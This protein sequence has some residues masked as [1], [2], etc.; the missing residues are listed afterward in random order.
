VIRVYADARPV[1]WA[2]TEFYLLFTALV[3]MRTVTI[4]RR[5]FMRVEIAVFGF[6]TTLLFGSLAY[7]QVTIDVSKVTCDQFANGKVG[8]PRTTAI[9]L[10]GYYHGE[11]NST[12]IDAQQ[13][14][15]I[16]GQLMSFCRTGENGK[17]LVMQ[18]LDRMMK[19][20]Q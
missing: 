18:V 14:E 2:C 16:F 17:I 8:E 19:R 11:N 3:I 7:G 9:W 5:F 1:A 4:N 13:S 15:D 20:K 10:N 6:I 12:T